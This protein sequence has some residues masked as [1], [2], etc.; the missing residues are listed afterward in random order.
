MMWTC[1]K[2]GRSF[3]STNQSHYCTKV[4][5][6]DEYIAQ[7]PQD[8]QAVLQKLRETIQRAAPDATEKI[9]WQMPTFWQKENLIQFAAHK[10]HLGL[11]PGVSAVDAFSE[12]LTQAG[13]NFSKGSVQLPWSKPIPYDLVAEITQFR[14]LQILGQ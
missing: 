10:N 3:Q 5:T 8:Q 1:P 4:S 11:Y 6:I 7:A 12:Q 13:Y 9:S 14:L 2:C